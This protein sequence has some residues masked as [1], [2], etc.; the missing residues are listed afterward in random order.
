MQAVRDR[1]T[2][3][4]WSS[5][6]WAYTTSTEVTPDSIVK[7][8]D[9]NGPRNSTNGILN[10]SYVICTD[11]MLI[12]QQ[13][14]KSKQIEYALEAWDS[15]FGFLT[16]NKIADRNCDEAE[17]ESVATST[18]GIEMI[19]IGTRMELK[20]NCNLTSDYLDGCIVPDNN[21]KEPISDNNPMTKA[22]IWLW[23][24]LNPEPYVENGYCSQLSLIAAHEAGHVF[25]LGHATQKSLMSYTYLVINMVLKNPAACVPTSN[26]IAALVALYQTR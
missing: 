25:G 5:K 12:T 14:T 11:A 13:E 2:T 4:P 3:S 15:L 26:D 10:Y 21:V 22:Q 17:K 9:I 8:V 1:N 7:G 19:G 16:T 18:S 20:D 24:T 6:V 23:K